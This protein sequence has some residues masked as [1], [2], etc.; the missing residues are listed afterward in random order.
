MKIPILEQQQVDSRAPGMVRVDVDRRGTNGEPLAAGLAQLGKGIG[1]AAD[2]AAAVWRHEQAKQGTAQ[3]AGATGDFQARINDAYESADTER[4]G[5]LTLKGQAA[6]GGQEKVLEELKKARGDILTSLSSPEAKQRFELESASMLE[7]AR[8]RGMRHISREREVATELDLQKSTTTALDAMAGA[9]ADPQARA[10][11]LDRTTRQV[12]ELARLRG[13]DPESEVLKLRKAAHEVVL[14]RYLIAGDAKGAADYFA[15]AKGEL[16]ADGAKIGAR[17]EVQTRAHEGDL[18][19][20]DIL[21]RSRIGASQWVDGT[22][23]FAEAEALPEG[24]HKQEVLRS[25][26][27]RVR[28]SD[29]NRK[30][31]G[32]EHL[33]GLFALQASQGST[34]NPEG[35][36]APGMDDGPRQRGRRPPLPVRRPPPVRTAGGADALRA[37]AAG[38]GRG[39]PQRESRVPRPRSGRSGEGGPGRDVR[40]PGLDPRD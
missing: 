36:R 1:Q 32:E 27:E 26:G 3:Y 40:R 15:T 23:A 16:G 14:E 22:K 2:S 38:A 19:A 24:F 7:Q 4:P 29:L 39:G 10:E 25:L 12:A 33:N 6:L 35:L 17:V 30:K 13:R 21:T 8:A 5:F 20:A 31:E 9:F 28:L 37:G 11:I 34:H 18:A